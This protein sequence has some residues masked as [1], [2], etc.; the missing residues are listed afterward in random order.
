MPP[1]A[2]FAANLPG[3][4]Y[5]DNIMHYQQFFHNAELL[6]GKLSTNLSTLSTGGFN[7][8]AGVD[9]FASP[10]AGIASG[11]GNNI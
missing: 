7:L 8:A 9:F 10:L 4:R 5:V 6:G 1:S 11:S 2:F 3:S